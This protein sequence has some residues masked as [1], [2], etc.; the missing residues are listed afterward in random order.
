MSSFKKLCREALGQHSQ[1]ENGQHHGLINCKDTKAKGRH[2]KKLTCKG[3]WRQVFIRV[4]RLE[5]QPIMLVTIFSPA[6]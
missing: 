5:I 2:L 6:L 3:T 1:S 4:Y